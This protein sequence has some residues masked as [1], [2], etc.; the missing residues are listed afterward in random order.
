LARLPEVQDDLSPASR[1]WLDA[2]SARDRKALGQY[3]TPRPLAD[4]LVEGLDLESGMRVLDP[5]VGTGELLAA[6]ARR[7]PGLE[8]FGWDVDAAALEAA[9]ANL[10]EA[11]LQ[12]RSALDFRE[13]ESFDAVIGNPPYFQFRPGPAVKSRF[14][15]VIS[16]RPNIFA[17]FFQAGIEVLRPGGQ[18]AYIVPPSLNSGAYFE[19]LREYVTANSALEGLT[20]LDGTA[21]FEGANTAVQ[22]LVLRKGP[23]SDR[24]IYQRQCED[25]GFRRVIFTAEPELLLAQFDGRRTLWDLGYEAATGTVVWNQRKGELRKSEGPGTVPLVWSHNLKAGELDLTS[26]PGKPRFIESDSPMTGPSV[27]VNRVVGSVGRGELRTALIPEGMEFLA[28]NHVNVIRPQDGAKPLV[29][30]EELHRML[31]A[32]AAAERI[33]LLTGNTQISAKELTHLLPL[34]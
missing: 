13:G 11:N 9:R 28:E 22:I 15:G 12:E 1:S 31:E 23:P 2:T 4:A 32:P 29:G 10:P 21:H 3:L 8:L 16:G 26:R 30:W 24:F 19:A 7:Q 20:V 27:L 14:S 17:F 34:G 33:R 5:G 25:S 6:A 18:L